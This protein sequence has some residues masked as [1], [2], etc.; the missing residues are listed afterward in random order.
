MSGLR[1]GRTGG[2]GG[3]TVLYVV[4]AVLSAVWGPRLFS[5]SSTLNIALLTVPG[6]LFARAML[7]DLDIA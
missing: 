2:G 7:G 3:S 6:G 5:S 1:R 4:Q